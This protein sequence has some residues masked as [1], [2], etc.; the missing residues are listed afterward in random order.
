MRVG[1]LDCGGRERER[2]FSIS[3]KF[4]LSS[5]IA[6]FLASLTSSAE[7]EAIDKGECSSAKKGLHRSGL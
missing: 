6:S 1:R 7:N 5:E 4:V 3:L 2:G